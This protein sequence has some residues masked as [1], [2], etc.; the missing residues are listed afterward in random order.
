MPIQT[1][2]YYLRESRSV[3]RSR[4][5]FWRPWRLGGVNPSTGINERGIQFHWE[6]VRQGCF[7][8]LISRTSMWAQGVQVAR[9]EKAF[10]TGREWL[11]GEIDG[12]LSVMGDGWVGT[13]YHTPPASSPDESLLGDALVL[14]HRAWC[15]IRKASAVTARGA[16][17]TGIALDVREALGDAVDALSPGGAGEAAA[18]TYLEAASDALDGWS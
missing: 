6:R 16:T 18:A 10:V 15:T 3:E 5:A 13:A 1:N 14:W 4:A 2:A 11:Q 8:G 7:V 9:P 17:L 12:I